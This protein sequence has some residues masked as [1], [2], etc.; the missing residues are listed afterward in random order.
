L[1]ILHDLRALGVKIAMDDFG[2]GYS[3]LNYLRKFPFDKL[4]IDKSFIDNIADDRESVAIVSA[5]TELA[6][7]LG[8]V[9]TAE[10]VETQQQRAALHRIGC[11][12]IQGYLISRP[13]P[14]AMLAGLLAGLERAETAA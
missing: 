1:S 12:E 7:S 13:Q 3:S 9:T 4:K 2:T 11:N 8:I 14:V 10:G 6:R 5:V